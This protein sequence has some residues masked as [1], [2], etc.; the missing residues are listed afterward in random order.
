MDAHASVFTLHR[1]ARSHIGL[2]RDR[3]EVTFLQRILQCI[4]PHA[5][6]DN[7]D[8]HALKAVPPRSARVAAPMRVAADR[9]SRH[10]PPNKDARLKHFLLLQPARPSVF[11]G[12]ACPASVCAAWHALCG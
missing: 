3:R 11:C 12:D 5:F 6:D 10:R 1:H 2:A 8:T 7:D 4:A 9:V